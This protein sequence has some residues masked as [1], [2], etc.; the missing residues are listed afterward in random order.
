MGTEPTSGDGASRPGDDGWDTS[1]LDEDFVSAAVVSERSAQERLEQRLRDEQERWTV[2]DREFEEERVALVARE[3]RTRA[4][5]MAAGVV[6]VAIVAG[7]IASIVHAVSS[8]TPVRPA[9]TSPVVARRPTTTALRS[10][11]A[12]RPF[13][14]NHLDRVY[15]RTATDGTIRELRTEVWVPLGTGPFPVIAFAH[16]N[17]GN[18][19]KFHQLFAAWATAGYVIVAPRF[20]VSAD[21]AGRNLA[22]S[23]ADGPEQNLDLQFVVVQALADDRAESTKQ[24]RPRTLDEDRLA[25]AGLSLGG[26]TALQTSYTDCCPAVRPRLV[27]AFSPV[28]YAT[29]QAATAP[30]LLLVHGTADRSLPYQGSVDYFGTAANRR[31]FVTL[32]GASHAD[33]YE[34]SPSPYDRLVRDVSLGFLDQFLLGAGGGVTAATE[35]VTVS[36]LGS[37]QSAG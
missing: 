15:R 9:T 30:P 7:L 6:I 29:H 11:I 16:G 36:G 5:R 12:R 10:V 27:I 34:D 2:A 14:V 37:I 33:P 19:N 35:A 31:W 8:A 32:D 20:P 13:G 1:I 26:G 24:D 23:V 17:D 18:P 21:D 25:I 28:P 4:M 22:D 3:R